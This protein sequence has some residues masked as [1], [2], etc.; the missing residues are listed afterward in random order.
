[1]YLFT[2]TTF[3]LNIY[4]TLLNNIFYINNKY[5]GIINIPSIIILFNIITSVG[6]SYAFY[7]RYINNFKYVLLK[8]Y[9]RF[10][11]YIYILLDFGINI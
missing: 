4:N 2:L 9:L 6:A 1:L 11:L 8:I 10:I 5:R 7:I 3:S